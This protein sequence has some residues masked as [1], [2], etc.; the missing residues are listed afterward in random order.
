M[1]TRHFAVRFR[2]SL[3]FS[4]IDMSKAGTPPVF[5]L[6]PTPPTV[7]PLHVFQSERDAREILKIC[8]PGSE[9]V[10]MRVEPL[11]PLPDEKARARL[12]ETIAKFTPVSA[13]QN[14]ESEGGD[15]D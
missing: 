2:E 9:V 1:T 15:H 4:H 11:D 6:Y 13:V 3:Y 12:D 5:C 8:P 7:R 10:P 14:D